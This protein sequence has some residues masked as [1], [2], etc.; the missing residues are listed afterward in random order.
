[1]L[2]A[3]EA[4]PR[5]EAPVLFDPLASLLH[6]AEIAGI[7]RRQWPL[8]V[9][10]LAAAL[11]GAVV[12]IAVTP[13]KFTATATLMIDSRRDQMFQGQP[14]QGEPRVD[15]AAVESQTAILR[16]EAVALAV[17][18]SLKLTQDEEFVGSGPG[19]LSRVLGWFRGGGDEAQSDYRL[20]RRALAIFQ[21]NLQVR[22]VGTTYAIDVTYTSLDP[23]R[24]A[25]IANKVTDAY[26]VGELDARYEATKRAGRWLQERLAELRDQ[27]AAADRAVQQFKTENNIV[28]TGR[29]LI[30]DQQLADVN[31]QIAAARA[32]TAEAK[33]RLDRVEAITRDRIPD[34]TVADAL[35]SDVISRLRAQFLDLSAREADFSSRFGTN[36]GAAVNLRNQMREIQRSISDELS[37]IAQ[38]Y[39]SDYEIAQSRQASLERSLQ[40]LVG[41]AAVTGQ[42][43]IKL[44][45]LES[46]S[47]TYRNLYDTF[48]QR[49]TESTQQ[50]TF[51]IS[52]ARVITQASPP[53]SKSAPK[54]TMILALAAFGGLFLGAAAAV[55]REL[56]DNVFRAPAQIEAATG[57]ECLGIV[58]DVAPTSPMM[59]RSADPERRIL[60]GAIGLHRFVVDAPF[61][62]FTETF[63][64]VKVA[65]DIAGLARE[66]RVIG[67][68][69][70]L[71]H[72]GKS[73]VASNFAQLVAHSGQRA[74]LIDG[75]LRNP[76]LTRSLAPQAANGLVEVLSGALHEDQVVWTDPVT[77]LHFLPSVVKGRMSQT[78]D[79][80]ASAAFAHLLA[81]LRPSYDYIVL[82]LPPVVP[83][84]DVR[85]AGHLVDGFVFVVE[86]GRTSHGAVSEAL[87]TTDILRDRGVGVILNKA[88][89]AMLKRI[90]HYKGRYYTNYYVENGSRSERPR[91]TA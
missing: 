79:L 88:D 75:D 61:S 90:E 41:E 57:L 67:I 65:A 76:S 16:S 73:T 80:L 19:I 6:P 35:R 50:Q 53:L 28:D 21:D 44:R 26:I 7:L 82:D 74:L 59:P 64:G 24:A 54:S 49:F 14:V 1:M 29:G 56:M 47:Q 70:A 20:E 22:R 30:G 89:P 55:A 87:A 12:Y 18:R 85:A 63:R 5:N 42:A 36:H 86:W 37:R 3:V 17:I 39:R 13:P 72:E 84:V 48:L 38:T 77:G 58:P 27:A 69:S 51:P 2:K 68:A 62:R 43:Q 46:A 23:A 10:C 25:E 15:T 66:L 9:A 52:E 33:A 60:S 32:T 81:R 83:V 8:V 78:A 45:D 34:A 11:L 4:R 40:Q 71:P 91:L 31:G